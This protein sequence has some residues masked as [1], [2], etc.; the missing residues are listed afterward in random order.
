[1]LKECPSPEKEQVEVEETN[2]I[3]PNRNSFEIESA[4]EE[5]Y[6]LVDVPYVRKSEVSSLEEA[7]QKIDQLHKK[8]KQKKKQCWSNE[9]RAAAEKNRNEKCLE[10][11]DDYKQELQKAL[12]AKDELQNQM[13]RREKDL[14]K[15]M[16]KILQLESA[17]FL[18]ELEK[19]GMLEDLGFS[20]QKQKPQEEE[21]VHTNK[22]DVS[23][24]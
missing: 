22:I 10:F 3:S 7:K 1:M 4:S 16:K 2:M 12:N 18:R 6:V 8:L 19:E 11:I 21:P 20:L 17:R 15:K 9:L 23:E 13:K 5:E 14:S 24:L